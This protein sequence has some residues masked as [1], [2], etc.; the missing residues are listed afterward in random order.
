MTDEI[1]VEGIRNIFS[2]ACGY[3]ITYQEDTCGDCAVK[4][5]LAALDKA[6]SDR[7]ALAAFAEW[8]FFYC[9]GE[10]KEFDDI[11]EQLK[12][13]GLATSFGELM[14]RGPILEAFAARKG[15]EGEGRG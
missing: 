6:E 12:R 5:L 10:S 3:H 9:D 14:V 15:G 8:A 7:D 2:N 11:N 1:T 4:V 13:C